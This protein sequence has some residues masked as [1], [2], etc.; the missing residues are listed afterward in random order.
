MQVADFERTD[1]RLMASVVCVDSVI[2]S[3]VQSQ[4]DYAWRD[5]HFGKRFVEIYAEAPDGKLI[6]DYG[7]LHEVERDASGTE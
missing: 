1:T 7:R 6:V 5:I 4:H 2:H 3:P